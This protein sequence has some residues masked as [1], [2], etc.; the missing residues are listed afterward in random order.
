MKIENVGIGIEEETGM[1]KYTQN[2]KCTWTDSRKYGREALYGTEA[3]ARA[4]S[5]QWF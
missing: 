3:I 4:Q 5:K 2:A 1:S